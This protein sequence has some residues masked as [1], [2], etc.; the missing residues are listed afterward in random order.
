MKRIV[1]IDA[2]VLGDHS[3]GNESYYRNLINH[4]KADEQIRLVVFVQPDYDIGQIG[5]E[6]DIVRFK[7]HNPLV[8]NFIEIPRMVYD[9]KIDILHMQYFIPFYVPCKVIVT[10]HDI[11]FEHFKGIFTRKDYITQ[12]L[13]IP[14]AAKHSD[15][16]FTVSEFSKRD[17]I[18]HYHV[19]E[20]KVVVTYNG[21]ADVYTSLTSSGLDSDVHQKKVLEDYGISTS[22]ILS[23]GNLQPR[24]NLQRLLQ[25]YAKFCEYIGSSIQLVIVG[26][27]AWMYDELFAEIENSKLVRQ[28]ILTD[29]VEEENLAVLYSNALFFVYPSYFEGFG[30]PVLEA[31]CCGVPVATSNCTS[32]PE[33]V[34]DA[35]LLFDPYSVDD[36]CEKMMELYQNKELCAQLVQRGIER[37]AK[38][39]WV[40]TAQSVMDSYKK[41]LL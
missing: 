10:I 35:G 16:I 11:S 13:L 21:A 41:L 18:K 30:I 33:V 5:G 27:K 40:Q 24:K 29:Y 20:E 3:G 25:A 1:G 15:M 28:I 37:A 6:C 2:H 36:I 8:R 32:L 39:S 23:V 4:M 17:I 9:Y 34:D 38:F 26:K 7:S 14:Y 22:Y 12:K 31:M 19:S